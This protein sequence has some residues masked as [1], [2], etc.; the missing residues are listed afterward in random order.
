MELCGSHRPSIEIGAQCTHTPAA[1][2][3]WLRTIISLTTPRPMVDFLGPSDIEVSQINARSYS[4]NS[5][6][7]TSNV[8]QG[9][10]T[11]EAVLPCRLRPQWGMGAN[12]IWGDAAY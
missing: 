6:S 9:E 3:S 5:A 1:S 7:S 2:D 10:F 12:E 11:V 8:F 4:N